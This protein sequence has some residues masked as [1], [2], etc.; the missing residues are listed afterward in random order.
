MTDWAVPAT[1]SRVID[2]DTVV[3]SADLGWHISLTSSVRLYGVD[4]PELNT[5]EGK[6]AR[7][8]VKDLLPD[9]TPI[10]LVSHKLL[11]A[12]D[13]YGRVLGSITLPNGRDLSTVLLETGNAV[14]YP[15][16]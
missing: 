2:G 10:T 15:D 12:T 14:P 7:D 5:D 4:C 1:V 16:S 11:G 6:V 13:K 3:V 8:F 9:G